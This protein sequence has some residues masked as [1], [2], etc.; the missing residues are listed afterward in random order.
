MT[1][2]KHNKK[3]NEVKVQNDEISKLKEL[4]MQVEALKSQK[5]QLMA[6]FDNY[7]KRMDAERATF[8]AIAN[9]GLISE[10]LEIHDDMELAL[11]DGGLNLEHAKSSLKTAQDKLI[12][13]VKSA[14]VEKVEVNV[15]DEFDRSKMEA[16]QTVADERNKN[17]V[18]VVISSAYK[19]IGQVN[20]LKP[21][22]VIVGK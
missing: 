6:D 11:K 4:E 8:G 19:Y 20:V 7:R 15:G 5:L 13:A 10:M 16:I 17:K 9:M 21:A 3:E 1:K 22:K 14:G 18:I 12:A 2:A